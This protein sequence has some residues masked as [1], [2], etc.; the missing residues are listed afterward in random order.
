VAIRATSGAANFPCRIVLA[1][2]SHVDSR[3][4]IDR[5]GAEELLGRGDMLIQTPELSVLR[6]IQGC[7][8]SDRELARLIG[9]WSRSWDAAHLRVAPPWAGSM[10]AAGQD[11]LYERALEL[12]GRHSSISASFLQRR[13][14]IGYPRAR[15]LMQRIEATRLDE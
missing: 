9:H 3:V 12:A 6:R 2:T 5:P 13:L 8:I 11:E 15:R 14:G 1:V 10:V 7:F 4:I